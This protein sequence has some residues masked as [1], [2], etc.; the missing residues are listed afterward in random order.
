MLK[1]KIRPQRA[2]TG[3]ITTVLEE[4]CSKFAGENLTFFVVQR[5]EH[6]LEIQAYD[7]KNE[8]VF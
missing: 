1:V 8:E 3:T 7:E 4:V 6:Y 5:D 2:T